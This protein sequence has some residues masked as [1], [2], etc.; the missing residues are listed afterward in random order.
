MLPRLCCQTSYERACF[1][2]GYRLVTYSHNKESCEYACRIL[3]TINRPDDDIRIAGRSIVG[4]EL[5]FL[6][7]AYPGMFHLPRPAT[8]IRHLLLSSI[9]CLPS[10]GLSSSS[11]CYKACTFYPFLISTHQLVTRSPDVFST[12]YYPRDF[13]QVSRPHCCVK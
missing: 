2:S 3:P 5:L 6:S 4:S 11:E 12:E 8:R 1:R 9:T 13:R 10:H 7:L